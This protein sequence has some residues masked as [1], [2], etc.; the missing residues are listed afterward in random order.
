MKKTILIAYQDDLGARSLSTF[1]HSVGYRVET[2]KVV[3]DM[4]RKVRNGN[5]SVV[6]LDD[7]I[8]GA[9]AFEKH[10]VQKYRFSIPRLKGSHT[11][12][13]LG[14][15]IHAIMASYQFD[16]SPIVRIEKIISI[17]EAFDLVN[18]DTEGMDHMAQELFRWIETNYPGAVIH[19]EVPLRMTENGKVYSGIADMLVE[20]HEGYILIDHKTYQG[21]DIMGH[22]WKYYHQL[23][24]YEKMVNCHA[25]K[26]VT[27]IFLFYPVSGI[28]VELVYKFEV[29]QFLLPEKTD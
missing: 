15:A 6:L 21:T 25:E 9:A 20:T 2:A 4:I 22:S 16:A 14:D 18:F 24:A 26:K 11:E 28:L 29:Y 17:G 12:K 19:R 3:S 23:S 1:L 5:A 27:G 7:E 8:E 10:F 13:D